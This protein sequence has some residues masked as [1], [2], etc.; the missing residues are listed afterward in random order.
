MAGLAL[1][2]KGT[3]Q[4]LWHSHRWTPEGDCASQG[5]SWPRHNLCPVDEGSC[6]EVGNPQ[7]TGA[8]VAPA[9][10]DAER[11]QECLY[12]STSAGALGTVRLECRLNPP[13][14]AV[15]L[16]AKRGWLERLAALRF[17]GCLLLQCLGTLWQGA[18]KGQRGT[19]SCCVFQQPQPEIVLYTADK[20]STSP[21]C[22]CLH[23]IEL[24]PRKQRNPSWLNSTFIIWVSPVSFPVSTVP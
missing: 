17:N 16:P 23:F 5:R 24:S 1:D 3:A 13:R 7:P 4:N 15:P 9:A 18:V 6:V 19:N 12:S 20:Q 10:R 11:L 2:W 14:A 21:P 8:E 22:L